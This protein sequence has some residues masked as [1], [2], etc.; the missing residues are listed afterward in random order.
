M[1]LTADADWQAFSDNYSVTDSSIGD[2][3]FSFDDEIVNSFAYRNTLKRL[4]SKVK[5]T[6][7]NAKPAERHILDEPLIELEEPSQFHD[8]P[9]INPNAISNHPCLT[10]IMT[11]TPTDILS[12]AI[13]AD[14]KLLLPTSTEPPSQYFAAFNRRGT[15]TCHTSQEDERVSDSEGEL[16]TYP[17]DQARQSPLASNIY[18]SPKQKDS[19][20][21]TVPKT[22]YAQEDVSEN[23]IDDGSRMPNQDIEARYSRDAE[24]T[25]ASSNRDIYSKA[26]ALFDFA[27]E[28]VD[29]LPLKEGQ[30][31]WVCSHQS[32][33]WLMAEDP[34][35]GKV[36]YV[37]AKFVRLLPDVEASLSALSGEQPANKEK[38]TG[39]DTPSCI[40]GSCTNVS[41]NGRDTSGDVKEMMGQ[42]VR[43]DMHHEARSSHKLP[44]KQ[45]HASAD[46]SRPSHRRAS[47]TTDAVDSFD[48]YGIPPMSM[49]S[50]LCSSEITRSSI[51]SAETETPLLPRDKRQRSANIFIPHA[52]QCSSYVE[53]RPPRRRVS[54]SEDLGTNDSNASCVSLRRV[55]GK[56]QRDSGTDRLRRRM[57][58]ATHEDQ[59]DRTGETNASEDERVSDIEEYYDANPGNNERDEVS[60]QKVIHDEENDSR[61]KITK[62]Y[63]RRGLVA[64]GSP[65][66]SLTA[67]ALKHLETKHS[68]SEPDAE[69][70]IPKQKHRSRRVKENS[71]DSG[72]DVP[73]VYNSTPDRGDRVA[74]KSSTGPSSTLLETVENAIMRLNM[75]EFGALEPEQKA[76]VQ[77]FERKNRDSIASLVTRTNISRKL[78][79]HANVPNPYGNPDAFLNRDEEDSETREDADPTADISRRTERTLCSIPE[80]GSP[81]TI[82]TKKRRKSRDKDRESTL[83]HPSH[84]SQTSL[85]IE[86]F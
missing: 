77:N 72:R 7:Q 34:R 62:P 22:S 70:S 61:N 18:A 80:D 86:Y 41:A 9:R 47:I 1:S 13:V 6:Q 68:S 8:G 84:H 23:F 55:R 85:L 14:L 31:T 75:P 44:R 10:P 59:Y 78:S 81:V 66:A 52:R 12:K 4:A 46:P 19:H 64:E 38:Q 73:L 82:F 48:R 56:P 24:S 57:V 42:R 37:P 45:V 67:A 43:D 65:V 33:G 69:P 63:R 27:R 60:A 17:P 2:E 28:T 50:E 5:A 39:I 29:E 25:I 15:E 21:I 58:R 11:I 54:V 49:I 53:S 71:Q 40:N 30:I 16:V 26:V 74:S 79:K 3:E 20:V 83:T 76:E 32:Q 36:G 35:T 51:L